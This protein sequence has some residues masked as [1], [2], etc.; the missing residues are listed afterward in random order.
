[1]FL[2]I[3]LLLLLQYRGSFSNEDRFLFLVLMLSYCWI[4]ML[5]AYAGIRMNLQLFEPLTIVTV[6]YAGIF[7]LKPIVD[8]RHGELLEHGIHVLP[9]GARATALF[10]LGYT[11]FFFSYYLHH[12]KIRFSRKEADPARCETGHARLDDLF[13]VRIAYLYALWAAVYGLCLLSM[14]SQGLSLRFIFSFGAEGAREQESTSSMLLFLT[15]FG[16][17]LAAL[18]LIILDR[19]KKL[20]GKVIIT[21][22]CAIYVLMRNARWLAL[23][24]LVSPI[25][26]YYL[27]RNRQPKIRWVLLIGIAGL[28]VFGWM[29]ANRY[30]L[31][32]GRAMIFW[33]LRDLT[34]S[35][36]L[37]P[38]ES[39][40][41]T[42]RAFYSMVNR[43]PS[44]HHYLLGSTFLYTAVMI[45]P[46]AVWPG[47]PDNPVRSMIEASLNTRARMS[48]TA[49]ANLG[50]FY[51]NFGVIGIVIGMYLL[52]WALYALKR[53]MKE[54]VSGN[55]WEYLHLYA[56]LYP[57]LFQWVARG[58]FCGNF[59][60]TLFAC[61]PFFGRRLFKRKS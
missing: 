23:V 29:Q 49:V 12:R 36:L 59:Y 2:A 31:A 1:M 22:F 6:I 17:T 11:V 35:N 58:N 28:S 34:L 37:A 53:R 39:D 57:L 30:G 5:M 56:I 60:L 27:K 40:L 18:W 55:Q 52:G 50:E 4:A 44:E 42:Y 7:I 15:N 8:L 24:F 41:S 51:A 46:R 9:G 25:T 48:G 45:I 21:V 33:G 13:E 20:T 19:S 10:V 26:L 14:L 43:F 16:V 3:G 61:L 54:A 32:R 38:L 47:K